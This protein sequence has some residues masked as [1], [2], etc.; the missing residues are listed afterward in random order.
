MG[1]IRVHLTYT[2]TW[3]L[4][5]H[6]RVHNRLSKHYNDFFCFLY[7]IAAHLRNSPYAGELA[8]RLLVASPFAEVRHT[9][10]TPQEHP[11]S[12]GWNPVPFCLLS[13]QPYD[14]GGQ[15]PPFS[16]ARHSQLARMLPLPPPTKR[17]QRYHHRQQNFALLCLSV[18]Q[19]RLGDPS[20]KQCLL[21]V[22][23]LSSR[24]GTNSDT[25]NTL[26]APNSPLLTPETLQKFIELSPLAFRQT[27]L[28]GSDLSPG[29]C[30]LG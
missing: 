5:G 24:E 7:Y 9:A 17:H 11:P 16:R 8:W 10:P 25:P 14:S 12:L 4:Q 26:G 15:L 6:Y 28:G 22:R 20:G 21:Q 3:K 1:F 27:A 13:C 30:N 29:I 23:A 18:L 2:F 19:Q